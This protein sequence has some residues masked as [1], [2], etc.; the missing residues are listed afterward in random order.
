MNRLQSY[1]PDITNLLN[2]PTQMSKR[3]LSGYLWFHIHENGLVHQDA[4]YKY[5]KVDTLL[6]KLLEAPEGSRIILFHNTKKVV[7]W[8][9]VV[10]RINKKWRV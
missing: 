8:W 9:D 3:N 4:C 6:S 1:K 7:D 5:I 2:T 10:D